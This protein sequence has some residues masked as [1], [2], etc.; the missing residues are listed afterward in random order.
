MT[1]EFSKAQLLNF[2]DM[3]VSKSLVNPNTG[4]SYRSAATRLLEQVSNDEDVRTIDLD[5]AVRRYNNSH[6]NEL[7]PGSLATYKKR[8]QTAI[9]EFQKYAQNPAAY[10]GR[11]RSPIENG[12]VG[13]KRAD[14]KPQLKTPAGTIVPETGTLGITGHPASVTV[15]PRTGLTLDYPLR[16]DFLAQVV[17]PRDMKSDEARR[18]SRF[19]MTLAH[20]FNPEE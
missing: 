9:E 15:A 18:L 6:P 12:S 14:K 17:V 10:K 13:V 4:L 3:L 1:N 11:G 19:I 8:V 5:T 20:D 7:S 16:A 2:I